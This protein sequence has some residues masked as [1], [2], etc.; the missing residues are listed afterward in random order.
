M[1]DRLTDKQTAVLDCMRRVGPPQTTR[2]IAFHANGGRHSV[3]AVYSTLKA[4]ERRGLVRRLINGAVLSWE[5][6]SDA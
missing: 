4:L 6:N 1:P 5:T 2:T 3:E